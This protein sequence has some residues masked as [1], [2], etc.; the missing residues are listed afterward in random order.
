MSSTN[1]FSSLKEHRWTTGK[2]L[3]VDA[4]R[5]S[6]LSTIVWQHLRLENEKKEK[7]STG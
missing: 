7:K 4:G 3:T 2:A 1:S 5:S 6:Y